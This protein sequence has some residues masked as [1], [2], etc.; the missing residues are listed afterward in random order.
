MSFAIGSWVSLYNIATARKR[1]DEAIDALDKSHSRVAQMLEEHGEDILTVYQLPVWQRRG[2]KSTNMLERYNQELKRRT[3]VVRIFP[4]QESCLRLVTA[5]AM[6][7]TEEWLG[8]RY[9]I[10][11][12]EVSNRKAQEDLLAA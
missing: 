6:E 9:L 11:E 3:R 12:D 1:M 5:L 10:F 8:R 4:N 2:M 7:M